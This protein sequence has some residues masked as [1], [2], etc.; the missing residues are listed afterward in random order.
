MQVSFYSTH[1]LVGFTEHLQRASQ[2]CHRQSKSK[3]QVILI[4]L[5]AAGRRTWL[6]AGPRCPGC[7]AEDTARSGPERMGMW[8][9]NGFVKV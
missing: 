7:S 5:L 8:M 2:R 1:H 9:M 6:G 3:G 4:T